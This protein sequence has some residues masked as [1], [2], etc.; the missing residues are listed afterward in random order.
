MRKFLQFCF[1][2]TC[3][4][5]HAVLKKPLLKTFEGGKTFTIRKKSAKTAKF[6]SCVTFVIQNA[7]IHICSCL[8][9]IANIK[10]HYL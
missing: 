3:I 8:P 2:C 4:D 5:R 1:I 9:T 6:F 7:Y 10:I